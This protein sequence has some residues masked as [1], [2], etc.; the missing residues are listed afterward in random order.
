VFW[1]FLTGTLKG[2]PGVPF[3]CRLA[4]ANVPS[5]NPL[6]RSNSTANTTREEAIILKEAIHYLE[7]FQWQIKLISA[8]FITISSAH[9]S[10]EN[11]DLNRLFSKQLDRYCYIKSQQII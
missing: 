4:R 11:L 2:W 9:N 3:A 8:G 5:N 10:V 7:D 6:T 1:C